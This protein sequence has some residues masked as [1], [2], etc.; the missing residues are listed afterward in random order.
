MLFPYLLLHVFYMYLL[1]YFYHFVKRLR[2]THSN[3]HSKNILYEE[4]HINNLHD[5]TILNI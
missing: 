2:D 3:T 5:S 4:V 1:I